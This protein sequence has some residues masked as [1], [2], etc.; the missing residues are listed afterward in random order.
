ME[1]QSLA[2]DSAMYRIYEEVSSQ[3]EQ[4]WQT[5]GKRQ[6]FVAITGPPG[7][8]KSTFALAVNQ[9][10]PES[11]IVPM[12]GYHFYRSELA[13]ME[14]PEE[15]FR[16]RGAHWTFNAKK[17]VTDLENLRLTHEGKFPSFDHHTGDPVEEDINVTEAHRIVL[18]EG[19]YLLIDE[20][21]WNH[22]ISLFDISYFIEG[23]LCMIEERVVRRHIGVG[24][25]EEA[26]RDR[27]ENNDAI[28]ARFICQFVHRANHRI[29]SI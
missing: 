10:L 18:I 11:I 25:S 6:I 5:L 28:N 1:S 8:G 20:N 23:D 3:I 16:R 9:R 21:P 22:L 29:V 13:M 27:V 17:F 24:L 12:D 26:A 15:A 4:L 14:D 2:T 7:A 19:N